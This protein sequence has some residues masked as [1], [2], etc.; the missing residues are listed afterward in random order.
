MGL[1]KKNAKVEEETLQHE[2][3]MKELLAEVERNAQNLAESID[4]VGEKLQ[5]ARFPM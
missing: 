5:N 1:F 4:K 3:E 2:Q